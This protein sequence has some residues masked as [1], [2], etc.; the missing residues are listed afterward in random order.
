MSL[1][2][3][4][5]TALLLAPLL[6][7]LQ[8]LAA[9]SDVSSTHPNAEAIAYVK[10]EGIVSGYPDGTYRPNQTI[11]RAEFVKFVTGTQFN[12]AATV[13]K[14]LQNESPQS[15]FPDVRPTDW[16]AKY[17][18]VARSKNIIGGYPDGMFRPGVSISFAE[19]AKVL[20]RVFVG[21]VPADDI[22]YRPYV[23]QLAQQN[24]IPAT[25]GSF[26]HRLTRG[27]MAEMIWRLKAG[28]T[29]KPSK[30][31]EELSGQA[32]SKTSNIVNISWKEVSTKMTDRVNRMRQL[33]SVDHHKAIAALSAIE[34]DA[35]LRRWQELA[36]H[37]F[38][39]ANAS[40]DTVLY[41]ND[42]LHIQFRY[43]QSW[44]SFTLYQYAC[45]DEHMKE[46]P[47][48]AVLW[49]VFANFSEA[50]QRAGIAAMTRD[51]SMDR[52]RGAA[53]SLSFQEPNVPSDQI[54]GTGEG[55][56]RHLWYG[57]PYGYATEATYFAARVPVIHPFFTHL[58]LVGPYSNSPH[59]TEQEVRDFL[60]V[61]H[62]FTITR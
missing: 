17:V 27:E 40:A 21:D 9:F 42:D 12:D 34:R 25:V 32:A 39:D 8:A 7:P 6:L 44:G 31:Y 30:T 1:R 18:C 45:Y 41:R 57:F 58:G 37:F 56:Q 33:P 5:R 23:R 62:S 50:N 53:E 15:R 52:G 54:V 19:G 46:H 16:F 60:T 11:N 49:G 14:C 28:M 24:V 22:W 20:V 51:C 35:I 43:P 3:L 10:A 38:L 29:N 47:T 48:E 59:T 61:V 13:D 36:K 55:Q 2:T 26:D 4:S